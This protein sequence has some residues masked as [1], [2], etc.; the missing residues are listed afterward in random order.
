MSDSYSA[1]DGYSAYHNDN[2]ALEE[3]YQ[4][5]MDWS[6]WLEEYYLRAEIDIEEGN[7]SFFFGSPY[8][9][10]A[11]HNAESII[12]VLSKGKKLCSMKL[13]SQ[14][15]MGSY[16]FENFPRIPIYGPAH[17]VM[18]NRCA[19]NV[20]K[21]LTTAESDIKKFLD[22]Q[23]QGQQI[24]P[25]IAV[26]DKEVL[27]EDFLTQAEEVWLRWQGKELEAQ[28]IR[29][30]RIFPK[31][32]TPVRGKGNMPRAIGLWIWDYMEMKRKQGKIISITTAVKSF[33][34]KYPPEIL[35][36]CNDSEDNY[37]SFLYSCTDKC[38]RTQKVLP[39]TWKGGRKTN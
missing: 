22:S 34:N 25:K 10:G 21:I 18:S 8:H 4:R 3:K 14:K 12:D 2:I 9:L 20:N 36:P 6:I 11:L 35:L 26:F 5:L 15:G 24:S 1:D 38:I 30:T 23:L 13:L 28:L 29:L 37:L 19:Y 7:K 27:L 17:H 32:G 33:T 31:K 39:F 16:F